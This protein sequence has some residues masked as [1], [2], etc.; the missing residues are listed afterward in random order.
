MLQKGANAHNLSLMSDE[1]L[2]KAFK[3][4]RNRVG[5]AKA[6]SELTARDICTRTA[7]VLASGD[8]DLKPKRKLRRALEEIV[9]KAS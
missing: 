3:E 9:K 1:E 6:I 7:D 4:Y 8:Y 2:M 5:R